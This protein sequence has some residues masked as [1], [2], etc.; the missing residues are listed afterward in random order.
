MGA[1]LIVSR[2]RTNTRSVSLCLALAVLLTALA[3]RPAPAADINLLANGDMEQQG[4]TVEALPGWQKYVWYGDGE[5]KAI[6]GVAAGGKR[7]AVLFGAGPTKQA[8]MQTLV[9]KPCAYRLTASVA[10]SGLA[11]DGAGQAGNVLLLFDAQPAI[12]KRIADGNSDW[13]RVELDFSVA[14]ETK[15][16]IY[17]FNYGSGRLFVDDASL[18]ALEGCPAL[19]RERFSIA[20]QTL[21]PLG[22]AAPATPADTVLAGYCTRPDFSASAVCRHLAANGSGAAEPRRS[23][24]PLR[25]DDFE[26]VR[27][28]VFRNNALSKAPDAISGSASARID[29]GAY[30]AAATDSGLPGDWRGYDWLRLEVRNASPGLASLTTEIWDDKTTGYWSRVNWP[31]QLPPGRST[32]HVPLQAFVGEKS[33]VGDRRRIDLAHIRRLVFVAAEAGLVIDDVRLE[34]EPPFTH[35][36][37]ELIRLDAGP[38]S[39][40]VFPG[41]TAL[42]AS[43]VYTPELGYGMSSDALVAKSED[44]RHPDDLLRDWISFAKGGL[45][46]DLPNGRYVVWMM[47]EDPGY[48][49]YFPNFRRR[50]VTLQ[51]DPVLD[52]RQAD[53]AFLAR[54]YSHADTEDWPGDDIWQRYVATRYRPLEAEAEVTDGKLRIRF[55]A[56]QDPFALALS[57]LVIFP[58]ARSAEGHAFLGELAARRKIAFDREY[59]EVPAPLPKGAPPAANAVGG[60]AWIFH[61]SFATDVAATDWP[62][63]SELARE[64]ALEVPLGVASPLTVSIHAGEDI[65]LVGANLSLPGLSIDP[66]KVRFKLKR[67]NGDGTAYQNA[68]LLLDPL[69]P[70]PKQPVRIAKGHTITLWFDVRADKPIASGEVRGSLRLDFGRHGSE[71][72]PAHV[73]VHPWTLPDADIPVGYLGFVPAY[74]STP[75]AAVEIKRHREA[76]LAVDLLRSAGMTS[77]SGGFSGPHFTGYRDGRAIIDFKQAD[78]AVAAL[79]GKLKGPLD[80]YAGMSIS[81]IAAYAATD[82]SA[83][84][85]KPYAAVL[86]DILSELDKHGRE[87]GWPIL[88]HVVGDEPQANA[89]ADSIAASDAHHAATPR[90]LTSVFTSFTSPSDPAAA[91]AGKVDRLF[92]NHHSAAAFDLIRKRGS[93]C[94]LYNQSGRYRRGIYLYRIRQRGC[95]GHMQYAFSAPGA[96]PWYGLDAREDDMGAVFTHPDGLR[97]T[98]DFMRYREA[99]TDYR[100][101]LA[102]EQTIGEAPESP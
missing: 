23:P 71:V 6:E 39:A 45:D 24:D 59:R 56:A 78:L 101:L 52:Q 77:V 98:L 87:G 36:F 33:V 92:L 20:E 18:V 90:S 73:R 88:E 31:S 30:M 49:E 97:P 15:V 43:T 19:P 74:P 27:A 55:A 47:L 7:S 72:L 5:T 63:K 99:V 66:M 9:L 42:D 100:H 2:L 86:Q 35:E 12:A 69:S 67:I 102:L 8:I 40:P 13:R 50:V 29:A 58:K 48:W 14:A 17:F 68:P 60:K 83:E 51:G 81:G 26:N 85:G 84:F 89:I 22:F 32:V 79:A 25:I 4:A 54:Y 93:T 64:L 70:T 61:R 91:L 38:R 65:E 80:T 95:L 53:G 34:A 62:E 44:R 37:P 16:V 10:S 28:S 82:T 94:S 46:F 3:T 11:P 76:A 21:A 57:A 96:D 1:S 41:F 75:F